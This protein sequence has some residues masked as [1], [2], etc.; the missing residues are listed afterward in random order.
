MARRV[1]CVLLKRDAE[2]LDYLPYPGDLGKRIYEN[3][4]KEAWSQWLAHQTMLINE[5]LPNFVVDQLQS[6]GLSSKCVAILGMAFKAES[7]DI[8]DS[9]SYKLK[10]LLEVQAR[11]VLCTDARYGQHWN[12]RC[13]MR[14]P[15]QAS[16][17]EL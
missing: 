9:L 15:Y 12:G 16:A 17:N 13:L 2:G 14:P 6:E 4:S 5:N 7:D 10:K 8:R 11:E 1:H 3:V